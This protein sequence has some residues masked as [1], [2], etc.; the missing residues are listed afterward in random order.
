MWM[1]EYT[2][3]AP[4]RYITHPKR[5]MSATPAKMNIARITSAPRMPQNRILCW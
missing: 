5:L 2:R 3:N 1:P 4:N